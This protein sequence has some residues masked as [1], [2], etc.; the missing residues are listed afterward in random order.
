MDGLQCIVMLQDAV[1]ALSSHSIESFSLMFS[2]KIHIGWY[3]IGSQNQG[4]IA[5]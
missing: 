5:Y 2:M 3:G 4:I 1:L